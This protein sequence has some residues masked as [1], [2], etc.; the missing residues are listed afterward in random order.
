MTPTQAI[1]EQFFGVFGTARTR[2]A[3][4]RASFRA[5][6]AF[7]R[8]AGLAE[9]DG[10]YIRQY[11]APNQVSQTLAGLASHVTRVGL[12][13]GSYLIGFS[14][15]A[16]TPA[17]M[18]VQI[19]DMREGSTLFNRPQLLS[20]LVPQAAG[21]TGPALLAAPKTIIEPG[22]LQVQFKNLAAGSNTVELLLW[23][24]ELATPG[25][26]SEAA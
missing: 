8:L 5:G 18:E 24:A 13:V 25:P 6:I 12:P 10:Y 2:E 1:E 9:M 22:V 26:Y 21:A 23:V 3:Q 7:P 15:F 17:S 16:T 4:R 11:A 20:N 14:G 19:Q